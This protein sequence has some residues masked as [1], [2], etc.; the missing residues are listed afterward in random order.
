[1]AINAVIYARS[2]ADCSASVEEQVACLQAVAATH[3]WMVA[4][5]FIDRPMP[6][7]RGREQRP[8]EMALLTAIRSGGVDMVLM[9]SIDRPGRSLAELVAFLETC[10]TVD[11]EIY[12]H[13]RQINTATSN[14]LSLFEMAAMMAHHLRQS[15]RNR[16]LRGQ[17]AAR[18]ANVRFGRPPISQAKMER[19]E[20]LLATGKSLREVARLAGISS[21]AVGRLKNS[22]I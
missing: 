17:A 14:G 7:K 15:H 12:V 21:S 2:S 9:F 22:T 3:G 11:A 16:I 10:R 4:E 18:I 1:M 19:A 20:A 6:I 8:N 13:D 5:I